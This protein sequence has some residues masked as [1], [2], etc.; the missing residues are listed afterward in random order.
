MQSLQPRIVRQVQRDGSRASKIGTPVHD[1]YSINLSF[2]VLVILGAA[3]VMPAHLSSFLHI[4][5]IV[6]FIITGIAIHSIGLMGHETYHQSFFRNKRINDLVGAYVFHYPFL[7]RF[8]YLK[9]NHM[10]HH[11][12]FGTQEDPD[13]DHW[14]WT[15]RTPE[16]LIHI[17][18]VGMGLQFLETVSGYINGKRHR[19]SEEGS[20]SDHRVD[21]IGVVASQVIIAS[22]FL[23]TG[24]M[25]RYFACFLLPL[26]TIAPL[27]E[28][29]RVF[30]EHKNGKL[31]VFRDPSLFELLVFS[32]CRFSLHAVHHL[33]PTVP[34]FALGSQ[35]EKAK[36]RGD[37]YKDAESYWSQFRE[38]NDL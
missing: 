7:G 6:C 8:H 5:E 17:L 14:N 12:K 37:G 13:R 22:S 30:C 33:A 26:I 18:K 16:H 2:T 38:G 21:L 19:T 9:E 28:D 15:A 1:L 10:R 11:R 36:K 23:F 29:I 20:R 25:T 35:L 32:R 3:L 34:W 24:E 4:D 27:I 31:L